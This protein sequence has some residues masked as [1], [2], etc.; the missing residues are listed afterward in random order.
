MSDGVTI[1]A[2][3]ATGLILGPLL[4]AIVN[5]ALKGRRDR[6]AERTAARQEAAAKL[7]Q[8]H[9]DAIAAKDVECAAIA[10]SRD[11]WRDE[12]EAWRKRADMWMERAQSLD[13]GWYGQRKP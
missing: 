9:K 13:D 11:Q 10:E 3:T 12:S 2:I 5:D 1:A 7:I 4:L 6:I 8:D